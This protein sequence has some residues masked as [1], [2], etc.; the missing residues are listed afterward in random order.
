VSTARFL[1]RGRVQGVGFRWF[2]SRHAQ[3]L[4]VTGYVRNLVDGSVEVVARASDTAV[5]QRLEELLSRGPHGAAV[6]SV[7]REDRP[8]DSLTIMRSFDIR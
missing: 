7:E 5:L 4:G 8:E 2:V 6:E 3:G 1:V